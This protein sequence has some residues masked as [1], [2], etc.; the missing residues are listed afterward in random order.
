[1]PDGVGGTR[2]LLTVAVWVIGS[3]ALGYSTA[4]LLP[5]AFPAWAGDIGRLSAVIVAEVYLLFILTV[6]GMM[7]GVTATRQ[8]IA[9]GPIDTRDAGFTFL[10][11]SS[12]YLVSVAIYAIFSALHPAFPT[13]SDLLT[14]VVAIGTDM[15]RLDGA[16]PGTALVILLRACVFAPIAEELFFRGALF[17]WLRTHLSGWPTIIVT[18]IAFSTIHGVSSGTMLPLAFAVGI[19]AGYARERTESVTPAMLVHTLQNVAVVFVGL[20]VIGS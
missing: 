3:I 7:G 15:G 20:A 9:I 1:M 6:I 13:V 11:W 4:V 19:A 5:R 17:G 18:A 10:L 8:R 14:Y 16:G 2:L 12:A